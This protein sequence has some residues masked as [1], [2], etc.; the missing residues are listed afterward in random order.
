MA[1]L[2][3]PFSATSHCRSLGYGFTV[4][5]CRG[6]QLKIITLRYKPL[7]GVVWWCDLFFFFFMI[8][9][10]SRR[11]IRSYARRVTTRR[12]SAAP[13]GRTDRRLVQ[14][15]CVYLAFDTSH[16]QEFRIQWPQTTRV[17]IGLGRR[18]TAVGRRGSGNRVQ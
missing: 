5:R 8:V 1:T 12:R 3:V 9:L 11:E 16:L 13:G 15:N 17:Y 18:I 10:F 6:F 4:K 14:N 2:K 7:R